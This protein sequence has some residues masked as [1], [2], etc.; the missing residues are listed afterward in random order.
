M[1]RFLVV[2][3]LAVPF[4]NHVDGCTETDRAPII[5]EQGQKAGDGGCHEPTAV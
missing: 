1:K 3:V 2:A 5:C 4:A